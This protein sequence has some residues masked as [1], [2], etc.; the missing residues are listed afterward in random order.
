[1]ASL[2]SFFSTLFGK[3]LAV[4]LKGASEELEH[5][6]FGNGSSARGTD[7]QRRNAVFGTGLKNRC[8]R[9]SNANLANHL[10]I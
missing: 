5:R 8:G 6:I 10:T 2:M 4:V 9:N 1:M 7:G 3:D